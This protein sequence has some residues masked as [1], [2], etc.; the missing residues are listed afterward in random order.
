MF[1]KEAQFQMA[2]RIIVIALALFLLWT[3]PRILQL[4]R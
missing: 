4:L 2:M 1:K 3:M